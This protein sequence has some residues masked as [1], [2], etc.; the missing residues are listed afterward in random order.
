MRLEQGETPFKEGNRLKTV[1]FL[2][3]APEAGEEGFAKSYPTIYRNPEAK[4][5]GEPFG[6][7]PVKLISKTP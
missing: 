4:G 5:W 3:D 2:G 7:R 6:A 1:T